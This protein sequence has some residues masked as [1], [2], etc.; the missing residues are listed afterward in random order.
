MRNENS[1]LKKQLDNFMYTKDK[2]KNYD[3]LITYYTGFFDFNALNALFDLVKL[4]IVR[5]EENLILLKCLF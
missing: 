4:D 5:K 3:E 2:F 1:G